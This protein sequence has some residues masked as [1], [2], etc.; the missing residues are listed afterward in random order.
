MTEPIQVGV[1]RAGYYKTRLVNSGMWVAVRFWYGQPIIDGEV[2]DRFERW[3]VEVDGK[4][5]RF[6]KK[7]GHRVPLDALDVWPFAA[8]HPISRHEYGFLRK[9]AAWAREHAPEHPAAKPREPINLRKLKPV[10]P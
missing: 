7:A 9:R 4:T 6:D 10:T 2:Q 3:C 5:C 8:G 1:P